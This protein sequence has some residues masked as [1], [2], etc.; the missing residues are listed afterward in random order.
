MLNT[1]LEAAKKYAFRASF[2]ALSAAH[3]LP[4][5]TWERGE[6]EYTEE[7]GLLLEPLQPSQRILGSAE[8][9]PTLCVSDFCRIIEL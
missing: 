1:K 7:V 8:A 6:R 2:L 5:H 9:L 3:I 4:A